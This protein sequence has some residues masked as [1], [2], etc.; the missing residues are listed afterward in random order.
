MAQQVGVVSQL[1]IEV[2]VQTFLLDHLLLILFWWIQVSYQTV[3]TLVTLRVGDS[4]SFGS[5]LDS[6]S[7]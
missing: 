3:T 5:V 4:L 7:K 2:S 6:S 1:V